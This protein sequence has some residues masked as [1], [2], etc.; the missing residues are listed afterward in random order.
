MRPLALA[1][2]SY[3]H[4]VADAVGVPHDA[5]MCEVTDTATAYLALSRRHPERPEQ[6]LMLLWSEGQGWSV[7]VETA[8]TA[9]P[10]LIARLGGDPVPP[11]H[12]VARFVTDAIAHPGARRLVALPRPVDRPGLIERMER[13]SSPR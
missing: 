5:T 2:Q 11:P 7:A 6:D 12:T 9:T 13:C 3:V 10:V 1:L 4:A 8:P